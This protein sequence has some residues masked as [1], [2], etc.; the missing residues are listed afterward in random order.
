VGAHIIFI[1]ES[2]FLLIP[3]VRK[4]WA[5]RGQTPIIHHRYRHDRISVISALSVSPK[6]RRLGL[7]SRFHQ[8]NILGADIAAFLH[9]LLCHFR[10][11]LVVI[12]DNARI[13]RCQPVRDLCSQY[14]RL[15]LEALPPYAPELNPV[16]AAWAHTKGLLANGRPDDKSELLQDLVENIS[17]FSRSQR[18]LRGFIRKS[19]LPPFLP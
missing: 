11:N 13:H 3:P 12:W 9:H 1:D 6:R 15:H 18:H 19:D 14:Q 2:G 7:Y 4:T 17:R 10:G 5:P 8:E 16:E